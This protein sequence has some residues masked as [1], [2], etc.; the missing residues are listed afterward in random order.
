MCSSDLYR[1]FTAAREREPQ[2]RSPEVASRPE[3][4]STSSPDPPGERQIS[5][6]LVLGLDGATFD[7]IHPMVAAGKLPNLARMMERGEWAPLRSTTPPVTFPA[8]S[9]FMTGLEPA[10]HGLFDF[11]QKLAGSYRIG[12]VNATDRRGS[13]LFAWVSKAGGRVLVLGVPATFP[14]EPVNGL[15]VPGFD[16]PVSQIGR[17][18][19]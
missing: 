12:F 18:H 4:M 11:T 8:W 5:P 19:V 6:L 7:V 17:A 3:P 15:L 10:G 16:A 13:S 1:G 9:S 2:T 14:A